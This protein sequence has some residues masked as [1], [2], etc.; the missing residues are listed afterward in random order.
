LPDLHQHI[1]EPEFICTTHIRALTRRMSSSASHRLYTLSFV[2]GHWILG[3]GDQSSLRGRCLDEV[4]ADDG[5]APE[6][7]KR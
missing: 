3:A 7:V 4:G 2:I 6:G 5:D 1:T